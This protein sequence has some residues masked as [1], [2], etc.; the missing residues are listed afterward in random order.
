[1]RSSSTTTTTTTTST[2]AKPVTASAF[3]STRLDAP[4]EE[5][6]PISL[7]NASAEKSK[8][9]AA[10]TEENEIMIA[11]PLV[12]SSSP[13]PYEMIK[14]A[15]KPIETN[16]SNIVLFEA[17]DAS[18]GPSSPSFHEL[19]M[20]IINHARAIANQTTEPYDDDLQTNEI[21]H[22][23]EEEHREQEQETTL[24]MAAASTMT[25]TTTTEAAVVAESTIHEQQELE[26]DQQDHQTTVQADG[27]TTASE[28]AEA[29]EADEVEA[30]AGSSRSETTVSV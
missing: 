16:A 22:K 30:T 3:D 26:Q 14:A 6:S 21:S 29:T 23:A 25:T 18:V 20:S 13:K 1:M 11:E 15:I 7:K 9:D 17:S 24:A 27:Q 4:A 5:S 19:T 12:D 28:T 2:T 8:R 10:A